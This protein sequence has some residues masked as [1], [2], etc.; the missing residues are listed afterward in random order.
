M[1][2]H[3]FTKTGCVQT[4][5]KN[6]SF[7]KTSCA[8]CVGKCQQVQLLPESNSAGQQHLAC[9]LLHS[10]KQAAFVFFYRVQE[11]GGKGST[12]TP[13]TLEWTVVSEHKLGEEKSM[14]WTLPGKLG[15]LY[16]AIHSQPCFP[17]LLGCFCAQESLIMKPDCASCF[18]L[19][20]A[21][22]HLLHTLPG[23]HTMTCFTEFQV[24]LP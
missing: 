23:C 13:G 20:S 24:R 3:C 7:A 5:L 6:C 15:L 18:F 2:C 11:G 12:L 16:V 22:N 17:L 9:K 14:V 4:V 21:D 19:M 8:L 10:I 1:G